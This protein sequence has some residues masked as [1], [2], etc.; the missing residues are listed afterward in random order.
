MP[1]IEDIISV[2][3]GISWSGV[4]SEVS[5]WKDEWNTRWR[6]QADVG[7]FVFI[8]WRLRRIRCGAIKC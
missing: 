3:S 5:G 4:M 8:K 7:S 6:V 1:G 2:L